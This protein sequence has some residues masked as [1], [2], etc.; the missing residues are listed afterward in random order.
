MNTPLIDGW[1]PPPITQVNRPVTT[2][3]TSTPY[4]GGGVIPGADPNILSQLTGLTAQQIAAA[5]QAL[6]NQYQLGTTQVGID[7][8]NLAFTKEWGAKEIDRQAEQANQGVINNAVSRGIYNSGI[9]V[10][11][12]QEVA[13]LQAESHMLLER[14]INLGLQNLQLR[15]A[16]LSSDYNLGLTN[17]ALDYTMQDLLFAQD[18]ITTGGGLAAGT[19]SGSGNV[20]PAN[21]AAAQAGIGPYGARVAIATQYGQMLAS[22]FGLQADGIGH[23]RPA[24]DSTGDGRSSTSDH[25]TGGAVDFYVNPADPA[26]FA[27]GQAMIQML[28]QLMA[29]GIVSGYIWNPNDPNDPHYGHIHVSFALPGGVANVTGAY[30]GGTDINQGSTVSGFGSTVSSPTSS[31]SSYSGTKT[32]GGQVMI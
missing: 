22:Q 26:Q 23:F 10:E 19:A 16:Q 12:Q 3:V 27:Q 14:D 20:D 2:Q 17:A 11:G 1:S 13:E 8:S 29:Q 24:S 25:I 28:N 4:N 21:I 32:S 5:Q 6:L 7:Q 18:F 31:T 15:L 30:Y 9:R